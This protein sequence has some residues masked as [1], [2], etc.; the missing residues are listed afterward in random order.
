MSSSGS[1]ADRAWLH[2]AVRRIEA[3]YN[4]SAD[5]H[6]IR[7]ELPRYPGIR[8]Y[9]KDESSHPT[10][11]LKHR[12][13]RSLFLYAL[14][15]EWIGAGTCVIEASSGSTAVSEA[16]IAKLL[17]L[18]VHRGRPGLDLG[19]QTR[20]HPLSR[21]RNPRR[22]GSAYCLRRSAPARRRDPGTLPRSVHLFQSAPLTGAATTTSRRASFAQMAH[23]EHPVP[24]LWVVCG[25][26]G[27]GAL[28]RPSGRFIPRTNDM[29]PD[30]ASRIPSIRFFIATS[31]IAR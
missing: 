13:A 30:C 6:L 31:M 14:C 4:R 17:G 20:R 11:S 2:E 8:L 9:L 3:D 7:L 1:A 26:R 16:Y 12:L 24:T 27:P 29:R 22:C 21:R 15:N 28:Q 18:R 25:A 23:E 10:G 5:T 19:T